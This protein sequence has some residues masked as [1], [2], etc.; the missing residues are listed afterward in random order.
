MYVRCLSMV[1]KNQ[2]HGR[3][4]ETDGSLHTLLDV[5]P[6]GFQKNLLTVKY[7]MLIS[8]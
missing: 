4:G 8:C 1:K 2:N 3:Q 5:L 7:A 6:V